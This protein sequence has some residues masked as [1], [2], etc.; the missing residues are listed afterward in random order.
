MKSHI[1]HEHIRLCF[2]ATVEH[3]ARSTPIATTTTASVTEKVEVWISS[4]DVV[5]GKVSCVSAYI[6][7]G[8]GKLRR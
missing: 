5:C 1:M 8:I 7:I 6:V 2:C 4:R 3:T